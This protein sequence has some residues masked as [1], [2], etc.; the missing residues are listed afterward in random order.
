MQAAELD[1]LG[2]CGAPEEE[3]A[4]EHLRA[5]KKKDWL[6]FG[7]MF[8]FIACFLFPSQCCTD[9]SALSLAACGF[10]RSPL[11]MPQAYAPLLN[12]C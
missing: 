12:P 3:E 7:K 8:I 9:H 4:L 10:P 5:Q 2:Q 6:K 1:S 11:S